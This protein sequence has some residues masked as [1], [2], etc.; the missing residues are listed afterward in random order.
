M[1]NEDAFFKKYP[2]IIP[3]P[4]ELFFNDQIVRQYQGYINT[5]VCFKIYNNETISID[6]EISILIPHGY[7]RNLPK[8]FL[9]KN[10]QVVKYDADYHFYQNTGQLCL[11]LDWEIREKLY[12]D[13][14]LVNLTD[15]FIIPHLA[16]TRYVLQCPAD[17]KYP[18]GEYPHGV[19]GKIEGLARRFNLPKNENNILD[20]LKF[21]SKPQKVANKTLCPF[22]CKMNYGRCQC[23]GNIKQLQRLIPPK[24]AINM[25]EEI[26]MWQINKKCNKA[27]VI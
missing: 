22:G 13:S 16:A 23:K 19:A 6:E 11:G 25:I 14:S 15:S 4:K 5:D 24:E 27:R 2:L 3:L 12:A 9:L 1:L 7:P 8:V 20:I 21:L 26:S 18:Q 17:R 10:G